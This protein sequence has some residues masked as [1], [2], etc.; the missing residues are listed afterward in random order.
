MEPTYVTEISSSKGADRQA[1]RQIDT[2]TEA[3]RQTDR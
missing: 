1:G 2:H 3:G